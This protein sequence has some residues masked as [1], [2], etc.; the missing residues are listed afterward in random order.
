[1]FMGKR[2]ID[3]IFCTREIFNAVPSIQASMTKNSMED[4][5]KCLHYSDDWELMGDGI[6]SDT[7]YDD[8]KV[9]ADPFTAV[10]RLKHGQLEDGYNKV[11]TVVCL[12]L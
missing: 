1:M 8:P 5:T 9:I 3:Q 11:C 6:W 10:H 2:S 4:L 7:T 12:L